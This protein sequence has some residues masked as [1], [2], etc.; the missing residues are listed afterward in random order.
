MI[1]LTMHISNAQTL[2]FLTTEAKEDMKMR[3][4]FLSYFDGKCIFLNETFLSSCTLELYTDAAQSLG[5]TGVYK[6]RWFYGAFPLEWQ[7]LNIMTLEFYSIIL[8]L[9][10]PCC[11][12]ILSCFSQIM[13]P[14][15]QLLI[16][17]HRELM[18]WW[19]WYVT[20]YCSAQIS[21]YASRLNIYKIQKYFGWLP[22]SFVGRSIFL[23]WQ[24]MLKRNQAMCQA[25]C[26]HIT[27][28]VHWGLNSSCIGSLYSKYQ[29][30]M[31]YFWVF[32]SRGI[33]SS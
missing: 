20:W 1:N 13:N 12:I 26:C 5:Y 6:D 33:R 9:Y 10:V 14:Y 29:T 19:E 22:L 21:T 25:S 2:L 4:S 32:F 18:K 16:N 27:F 17:K 31:D 3:L 7:K 23:S 30:C 28:W 15:Y 11:K 24:H 8:A